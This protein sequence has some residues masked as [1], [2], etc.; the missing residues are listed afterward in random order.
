M[1][2]W[3]R[4]LGKVFLGCSA[5]AVMQFAVSFPQLPLM[6]E[7]QLLQEVIMKTKSIHATFISNFS[8][9]RHNTKGS[10]D[11][12]PAQQAPLV[13]TSLE[14][15]DAYR[16]YREHCPVTSHASLTIV[17]QPLDICH[18]EDRMIKS[19]QETQKL[20]FC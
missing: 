1:K 9:V 5:H 20:L 11:L 3:V 8:P 18:L 16:L 13:M 10:T 4:A 7:I 17:F 15:R 19:L 2:L 14:A 12:M 6:K